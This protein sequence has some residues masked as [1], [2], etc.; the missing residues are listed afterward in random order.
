M[1]ESA[2]SELESADSKADSGKVGVWVLAFRLRNKVPSNLILTDSVI[3]S[4]PSCAS[5]KALTYIKPK[6]YFLKV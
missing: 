6:S 2:D 3:S 4:L 5:P 1:L